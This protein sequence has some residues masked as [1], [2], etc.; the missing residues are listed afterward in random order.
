MTACALCAT[1]SRERIP[2]ND[3]TM[4][5]FSIS[6]EFAVTYAQVL[7]VMRFVADVF[8]CE[9]GPDIGIGNMTHKDLYIQC[10]SK[11]VGLKV[12]TRAMLVIIKM[13]ATKVTRKMLPLLAG[14]LPRMIQY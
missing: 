6:L 3:A 10:F 4:H 12:R 5:N 8:E 9:Y 13:A 14:N 11:M 2:R 1:S 7:F